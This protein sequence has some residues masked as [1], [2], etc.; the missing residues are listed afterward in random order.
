MS[1]SKRVAG[2]HRSHGRSSSPQ[3]RVAP[4]WWVRQHE[5]ESSLYLPTPLASTNRLDVGWSL[6]STLDGAGAA[7]LDPRGALQPPGASWVLDWWFNHD[8]TW[9]RA[10]SVGGV[11]QQRTD[12]LPV[13]DTRVR[14]GPNELIVR[15]AAAPRTGPPGAAWV[16]IEVEVD[17]PDPVGL[18]VVATPWTLSDQGRIDRVEVRNG[19]LTV[20]GRPMLVAERLP[21]AVHVVEVADDLVDELAVIDQPG[22]AGEGSAM[23]TA[24]NAA[25]A[26]SSGGV[27][28]AALVWPMAHRSTLRLG[29]AIGPS[30]KGVALDANELAR[31]GDAAAVAN[32]WAVHLSNEPSIEL[33]DPSLNAMARAAEAQLLA[34]SEGS[35]FTGADAVSAAIAAGALARA[36]H[37]EVARNVVGE[38]ARLTDDD[39]VGLA[40][41]LEACVGLGLTMSADEVAD[42]PEDLLVH[43][44]RA[45]HVCRRRLRRH[46][47]GWW[48]TAGR[49]EM[50]RL[51]DAAGA[52]A[53]A[54]GQDGVADNAAAVS[55]LLTEPSRPEVSEPEPPV[56]DEQPEAEDAGEGT[57]PSPDLDGDLERTTEVRWVR[58]S[59][60]AD[61]DLPATLAAARADIAR[62]DHAG[63][64]TVAAVASLLA[65]LECWPNV[66]H[67][68][69]PLGVGEDGAS[70]ATMAQ[71]LAAALELSA[72]VVADNVGVFP[73]F[74][75]EWWGKP[76]QFVALPVVGGSASCALRWHGARPALIWELSMNAEEGRGAGRRLSAPT[77]DPAFET[78]DPEGEALLEMPPGAAEF[79]TARAEAAATAEAQGDA[80][81]PEPGSVETGPSD[82]GDDQRGDAAAPGG[83]TMNVGIPT[84]RRS[85]DG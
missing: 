51:V 21:R 56:P 28:G 13:A 31:V 67:P 19:V 23:E 29:L 46:G 74:P 78:S 54:W 60:G 3:T 8:G 24:A 48:P 45:L 82:T 32:G 68:T 75:P 2:S 66:V 30:E 35:W 58:R 40:A 71:L 34:A 61:L 79:L 50:R 41:V 9:K 63:A 17:G 83:V 16:T 39:P 4:G 85:D 62:G 33:P 43:L 14:V 20:N 59:P 12:G 64:A 72:P 22:S 57:D 80:D 53:D 18:A 36:G 84:R 27:A 55:E 1:A 26:E 5:P 77:L 6:V 11:R 69:R 42:A 65:R 52:L 7:A 73:A 10:S 15:H 38:V 44:G 76:A 47:I 81:S 37:P 25:M 49:S 70:V